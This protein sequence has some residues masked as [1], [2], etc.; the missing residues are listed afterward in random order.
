[1]H[2]AHNHRP[3]IDGRLVP[4]SSSFR[5]LQYVLLDL[6][7]L[8]PL[9]LLLYSK[10]PTRKSES[11]WLLL[12]PLLLLPGVTPSN[13]NLMVPCFS[14]LTERKKEPRNGLSG[15]ILDDGMAWCGGEGE[16]IV[17][18]LSEAHG[19]TAAVVVEIR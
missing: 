14:P 15:T 17:V 9:L 6:F 8:F 13:L 4:S 12:L 3:E 19:H 7:I 5:I 16:G 1:M 10:S 11:D 2:S 18:K